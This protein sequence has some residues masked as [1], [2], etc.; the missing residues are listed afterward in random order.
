M[1]GLVVQLQEDY[2]EL[3]RLWERS[4]KGLSGKTEQEKISKTL[5][6]IKTEL[7][8]FRKMRCSDIEGISWGKMEQI[9]MDV[10]EI[11]MKIHGPLL[12]VSKETE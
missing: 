8:T 12:S 3:K 7:N 10:K 2:A 1:R 11:E 6:W 9:L 5:S 4:L